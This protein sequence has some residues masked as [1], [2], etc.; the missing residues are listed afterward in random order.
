VF[1]ILPYFRRIAASS[2]Y[3]IGWGDTKI[4]DATYIPL[5]R[6]QS[7][8]TTMRGLGELLCAAARL[9]KPPK[10]IRSAP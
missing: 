2:L 5:L 9:T 1:G 4:K 3:S 10:T 6:S 7:E 8:S